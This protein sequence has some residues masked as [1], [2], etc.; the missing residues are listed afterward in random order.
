MGLK[1]DREWIIL[2]HTLENFANGSKTAIYKYD[3]YYKFWNNLKTVYDNFETTLTVP[4][5]SVTNN[6]Y[7]IRN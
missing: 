1:E 4:V 2:S 6:G 5:V 3:K 7:V